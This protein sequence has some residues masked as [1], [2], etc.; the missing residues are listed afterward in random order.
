MTARFL[1]NN[2]VINRVLTFT[3]WIYINSFIIKEKITEL[4]L[5]IKEMDE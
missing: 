4:R 5:E 2:R 3:N 1:A